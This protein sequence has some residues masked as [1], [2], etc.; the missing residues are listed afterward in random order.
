M[1]QTSTNL[2]KF[3][4]PKLSKTKE[5]YKRAFLEYYTEMCLEESLSKDL[6]SDI[7]IR[8]PTVY[9]RRNVKNNRKSNLLENSSGANNIIQFRK[10]S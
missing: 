6:G 1:S 7:L 10:V 2:P 8:I 3:Y 9:Q 5:R 4:I